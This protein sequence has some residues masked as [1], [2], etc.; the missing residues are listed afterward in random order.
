MEF[1]V[2]SDPATMAA[3][4]AKHLAPAC[5][6]A[7]WQARTAAVEDAFISDDLTGAH[8]LPPNTRHLGEVDVF[9]S[10]AAATTPPGATSTS[11]QTKG[12]TSSQASG[13]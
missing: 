8:I 4:V 1:S 6:R 10:A 7:A 11:R 9:E 13:R 12:P 2:G 5:R 3:E